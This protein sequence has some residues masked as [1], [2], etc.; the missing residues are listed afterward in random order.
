[1]I[2]NGDR[3]DTADNTLEINLNKNEQKKEIKCGER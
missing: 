1:M 3:R 2:R